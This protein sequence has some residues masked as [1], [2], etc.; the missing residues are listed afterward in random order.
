M[1]EAPDVAAESPR[2]PLLTRF[3]W[4]FGLLVVV[5]GIDVAHDLRGGLNPV[6]AAVELV[7]M[8]AVIGTACYYWVQSVRTRAHARKLV[9]RLDRAQADAERWRREAANVLPALGVAVQRQME[10]WG[11]SEDERRTALLLLSGL[12]L[13]D[14]ARRL[15]SG[16]RSV[17]QLAVS[18]YRKAG[19]TGRAELSAFFLQDLFYLV[20]VPSDRQEQLAAEL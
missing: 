7:A 1:P 14:I 3:G 4:L 17:R 20:G 6:V 10:R 2:A 18:I 19:V 12:S 9:R 13:Q 11:L 15:G 5:A 8:A 16:T